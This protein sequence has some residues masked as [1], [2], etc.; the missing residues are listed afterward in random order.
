M[1]DLKEAKRSYKHSFEQRI[2]LKESM[3]RAKAAMDN[4]KT[5][6]A[7]NFSGWSSPKRSPNK[8][9]QTNEFGDFEGEQDVLDDQEAFDRLEVERVVA[10]D[11]NSLAFF[12]AQKTRRALITQNSSS[13]KSMQ[14][15]KRV[16]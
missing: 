5:Q 13:I 7:E 14:K 12:Q 15:N 6:L 1:K 10:S 9:R 16:I 2:K 11:P 4:K 3:S 8:T